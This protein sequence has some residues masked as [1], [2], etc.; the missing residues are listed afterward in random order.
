MTGRTMI[1]RATGVEETRPAWTVLDPGEEPSSGAQVALLGGD[2]G[3]AVLLCD[4]EPSAFVAL[5]SVAEAAICH[6][7][8]GGGSVFFD[9]GEEITFAAG[10][11]IQFAG[12]VPHGWRIGP[13]RTTVSVTTY[14][15]TA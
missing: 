12:D 7:V 11:T 15:E 4:L 14:P 8:T 10:D 9:D 5:H 13:E 2:A 3:V 6:V 1:C